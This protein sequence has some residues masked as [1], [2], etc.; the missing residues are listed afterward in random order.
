MWQFCK[1]FVDQNIRLAEQKLVGVFYALAFNHCGLSSWK[2]MEPQTR[3]WER[4]VFFNGPNTAPK[5][6]KGFVCLVLR[7]PLAV[8]RAY[9]R[10]SDQELFL[11]RLREPYG[12]A[13]NWTWISHMQD[14]CLNYSTT[15]LASKTSQVFVIIIINEIFVSLL[16]YQNNH[17]P[18]IA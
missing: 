5:L 13:R 18:Q 4:E 6:T 1:H 2:N 15:S 11:V 9:S 12:N 14:K 3:G 16:L 17:F 10:L 8:V 7:S